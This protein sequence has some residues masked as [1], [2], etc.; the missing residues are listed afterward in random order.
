MLGHVQ[1]G[2]LGNAHQVACY[3][4]LQL[5]VLNYSYRCGFA[6]DLTEVAAAVV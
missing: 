4:H 2:D 5:T 6:Y 1:L 3:G